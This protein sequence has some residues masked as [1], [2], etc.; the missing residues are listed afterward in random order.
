MV[1]NP[2]KT[3]TS[4]LPYV[5]KYDD[6]LESA[7]EVDPRDPEDHIK[8]IGATKPKPDLETE[9][10]R[11]LHHTIRDESVLI[12]HSEETQP[13]RENNPIGE[14]TIAH[15]TYKV[16]DITTHVV[17]V[18]DPMGENGLGTSLRTGP[19]HCLTSSP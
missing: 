12:I 13:D 2:D 6:P 17:E 10:R 4:N 14:W 8:E 16:D 7:E 15:A 5:L 18:H 3:L 11:A 1:V 9:Y 19:P